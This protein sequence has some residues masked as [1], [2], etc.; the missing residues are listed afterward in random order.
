M[1]H[2]RKARYIYILKHQA[3][4][5]S[6]QSVSTMFKQNITNHNSLLQKVDNMQQINFHG[7]NK[8]FKTLVF[9]QL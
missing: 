9:K 3:H 2:L 4:S 5:I 1:L 7:T 8:H 6:C